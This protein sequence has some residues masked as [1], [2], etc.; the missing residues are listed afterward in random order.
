MNINL[1]IPINDTGYGVVSKNIARSLHK[2]NNVSIFPIGQT[3]ARSQQ[4]Y[5]DFMQMINNSINFEH[6]APTLKIWHQ[7]DL[8]QHIGKG[9]YTAFPFFELDTFDE[10]EKCQMKVPDQ[11]VVASNWAKEV[12]M[13]NGIT[14]DIHVVPMGVDRDIFNDELYRNDILSKDKYIFLT[15]GKW[16]VRKGHDLL[17]DIFSKAFPVEKDVELWILAAEHTSSYCTKEEIEQWKNRYSNDN[18]IRIIGGTET[19]IDIAKII[20]YSDC[21]LYISRAEGWNLELLETMSMNKPCIASN[22]SG[23][24]EFCDNNNTYLVDIEEKELAFDGKAFRKQGNWAKLSEKQIE[25]TVE[26]MRY[27]YNNNIRT[28]PQGLE[29]AQKLSWQNTANQ[30]LKIL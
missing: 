22:Y 15:I 27:V 18:R 17:N 28:N 4:E 25:Q 9:K 30:I 20:Q 24:T 5:D 19:H 2:N 13:Q 29:T 10:R 16:E 8:A 3:V 26:H 11:Y 7:F 14:Q 6:S 1:N 23:H 21:G 12:L